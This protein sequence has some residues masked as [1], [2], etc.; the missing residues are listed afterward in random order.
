MAQP[1]EQQVAIKGMKPFDVLILTHMGIKCKVGNKGYCTIARMVRKQ[2][3]I[4]MY[5]YHYSHTPNGN[6]VITCYTEEPS[7]VPVR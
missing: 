4:S 1:S 2:R 5:D 7:L 6:V 3:E